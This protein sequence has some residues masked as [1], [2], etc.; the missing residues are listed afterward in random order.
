MAQAKY[1][2]T[3][4]SGGSY[5]TGSRKK[6]NDERR[7]DDNANTSQRVAEKRAAA[8]QRRDDAANPVGSP[9]HYA[10]LSAQRAAES[11]GRA[12]SDAIRPVANAVSKDTSK[13]HNPTASGSGGSSRSGNGSGRGGKMDREWKNHKW[14]S[15]ER[16]EDGKWVYDYGL[17]SGGNNQ[18]RTK[19]GQARANLNISAKKAGERNTGSSA[20]LRGSIQAE[21]ISKKAQNLVSGIASSAQSAADIVGKS[22][23][24]VYN[25]G[26]QALSEGMDFLSGLAG[27]LV[28]NITKK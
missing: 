20:M 27:G 28:S 4:S 7:F 15:R 16:N 1:A 19:E 13:Y 12:F 26:S 25:Q 2:S 23:S 8:R 17:V 9:E 10:R 11:A 3:R 24:D 18:K 22:V 6:F 21:G 5:S 14:I